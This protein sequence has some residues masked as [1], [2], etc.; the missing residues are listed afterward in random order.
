V[1][2]VSVRVPICFRKRLLALRS[3]NVDPSEGVAVHLITTRRLI[4]LAASIAAVIAVSGAAAEAI[5]APAPPAA[6]AIAHQRVLQV[7]GAVRHRLRLGASQLAA[8]PHRR[9]S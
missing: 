8:L 2:S 5:P 6:A 7:D 4:S 9:S 3:A 1:A